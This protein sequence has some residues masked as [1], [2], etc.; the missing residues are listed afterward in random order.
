MQLHIRHLTRYSYRR[1]VGLQPH[2]L[3]LTPR[4]GHETIV[5]ESSI[6]CTPVA[7]IG[8]TQD[9]FA[10]LIAT[11]TFG[12]LTT[13]LTIIA[14]AVVDQMSAQWPIFA[15]DP[16]AQYY[17]FAYSLDEVIDLG[18]L[19]QPD[20][21]DPGT[22]S[23]GAWVKKF[24]PDCLTD[25]LCL[26]KTINAGVLDD[27]A[28]RIRDE[29][30]TQTPRRTLD[31]GSGSCRDIAALFIEAVRHLGFGARAVSGYLYAPDA[32]I[33]D[34]GSTHAWAEVYLP[35]A[36]W[37]AFD[38]THR[39]TGGANLVP[40]AVARANSQIMPV[41]GGYVGAAEDF[42]SIVVSVRVSQVGA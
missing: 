16:G 22:N 5:R 19:R 24:V 7:N 30:G 10:N 3:I 9:V 26:L 42:A 31:L 32:A 13:E 36:G 23:V 27:V 35:M 21:L 6:D 20:W 34:E 28:Y 33:G 1:P 14:E 37:I 4:S 25:T 17:P 8:W 29:E 38:P 41:V 15:I 39:R 11:A 18:Q 40:V 12:E 2:R